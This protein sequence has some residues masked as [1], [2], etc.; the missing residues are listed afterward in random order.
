MGP[1]V[2]AANLA[3]TIPLAFAAGARGVV[4]GTLGA[5]ALGASWFF[6]RLRRHVPASPVRG[7]ARCR[8]RAGGGA[9]WRAPRRSPS[10]SLAVALLPGARSRCRSWRSR[11]SRSRW[12]PTPPRALGAQASR[13]GRGLRVVLG[14]EA[15][16]ARRTT[17]T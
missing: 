10:G 4:I 6:S 17:G 13:A 7:A 11:R 8:H 16:G 5:Y 14:G 9:R 2:V 3:L 1:L 12:R 15:P